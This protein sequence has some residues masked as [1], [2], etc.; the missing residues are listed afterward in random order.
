MSLPLSGSAFRASPHRPLTTSVQRF[1]ESNA[2]EYLLGSL[3]QHNFIGRPSTGWTLPKIATH[4]A[5]V[6]HDLR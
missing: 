2:V 4:A 3:S 1:A 6:W 5:P